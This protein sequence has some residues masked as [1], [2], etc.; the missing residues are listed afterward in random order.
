MYAVS[1]PNGRE[2]ILSGDAN[3]TDCESVVLLKSVL[4]AP[5]HSTLETL[6]LFFDERNKIYKNFKLIWKFT[7]SLHRQPNGSERIRF[8]MLTSGYYISLFFVQSAF[9]PKYGRTT[10]L[11]CRIGVRPT[12]SPYA[13]PSPPLPLLS[14]FGPETQVTS[15]ANVFHSHY[16]I[17]FRSC[18]ILSS[19]YDY[20]GNCMSFRAL[21]KGVVW[22]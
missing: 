1:F 17:Y 22:L 7:R 20:T 11:L 8:A 6:W 4:K 15:H 21:L 12:F 5:S 19:A 9:R 14:P 13:R 2:K 3:M 16:K 18:D 10:Q